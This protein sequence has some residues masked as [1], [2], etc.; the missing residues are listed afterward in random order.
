VE[1]MRG[2]GMGGPGMGAPGMGGG[3]GQ[4]GGPAK[5]P[6]EEE[7]QKRMEQMGARMKESTTLVVKG[8]EPIHP[9]QVITRPAA[10]GKAVMIF[11]FPRDVVSA[12]AKDVEFFTQAGPMKVRA[13][14]K[15]AD[16]QYQSK[17]EY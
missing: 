11:L 9:E 1:G 8:K 2:P 13:K 4:E 17:L 6:T 10:E 16:M 14:F 15:L 12:D 5:P 7:R 3:R